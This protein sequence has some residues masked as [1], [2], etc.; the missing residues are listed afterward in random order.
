MAGLILIL[1]LILD[2]QIWIISFIHD[3]DL[4][5]D[6][7]PRSTDQVFS[8]LFLILILILDQKSESILIL[9][10]DQP[11]KYVVLVLILI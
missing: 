8:T 1:S 6:L 4:D 3:P 10:L 11:I 2:L 9:I 7:G 5:A